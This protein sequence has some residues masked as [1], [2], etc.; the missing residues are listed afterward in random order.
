MLHG[1]VPR[2]V[3]V[4]SL[5][6]N[7]GG[8]PFEWNPTVAALWLYIMDLYFYICQKNRTTEK[9]QPPLRC[10]KLKNGEKTPS[11]GGS[12]QKHHS[13][14]FFILLC[15][16]TKQTRPSRQWRK[17]LISNAHTD[18]FHNPQSVCASFHY[19][20]MNESPSLFIK[21]FFFGVRNWLHEST[22]GKDC[23]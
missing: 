14:L 1:G 10:I 9:I 23:G 20:L 7:W 15:L 21:V 18:R 16:Q 12:L 22:P 2:D 8:V 19:I 5:A 13:S 17:T 4:L 6:S 11:T 3:F